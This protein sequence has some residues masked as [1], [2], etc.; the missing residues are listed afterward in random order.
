LHSKNSPFLGIQEKEAT[1]EGLLNLLKAEESHKIRM[2]D[3]GKD[4]KNQL[5]DKFWDEI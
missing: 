2:S 4:I 5:I 1:Q 3:R